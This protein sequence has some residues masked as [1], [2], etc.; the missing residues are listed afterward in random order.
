MLQ[1]AAPQADTEVKTKPHA[2]LADCVSPG[3]PGIS[4]CQAEGLRNVIVTEES[5]NDRRIFCSR[6]SFF[7]F[8]PL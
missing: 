4:C 7:F 2:G 8:N 3:G 5:V 6:L 1:G